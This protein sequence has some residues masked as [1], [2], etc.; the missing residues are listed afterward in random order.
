MY[1]AREGVYS[2]SIHRHRFRN[3]AASWTWQVRHTVSGCFVNAGTSVRSHAH[4]ETEALGAI[5]EAELKLRPN[6]LAKDA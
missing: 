1:E 6:G 2:Y 5:S 4:A 3:G